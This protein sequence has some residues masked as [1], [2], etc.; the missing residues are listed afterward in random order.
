VLEQRELVLVQ[1][2]GFGRDDEAGE[3]ELIVSSGRTRPNRA[4]ELTLARLR[5]ALP[6][7][8]SGHYGVD[9]DRLGARQNVQGKA[10]RAVGR[11]FVHLELSEQLREQLLDDRELRR[12]FAGALP[13]GTA[14]EFRDAC[15]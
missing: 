7:H 9:I 3:P 11:C 6:E 13:G 15:R 1:L 2:H 5:A 12:R 10:A 4:S 8:P 14:E